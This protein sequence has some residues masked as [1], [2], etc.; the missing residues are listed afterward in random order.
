MILRPAFK[1]TKAT[2]KGTVHV[3]TRMLK[4]KRVRRV[5]V[6]VVKKTLMGDPLS[7]DP[8]D[9]AMILVE[10]MMGDAATNGIEMV[11]CDPV[12][13][14]KGKLKE[15][16]THYLIVEP[17]ESY[18]QRRRDSRG[19]DE[20]VKCRATLKDAHSNDVIDEQVVEV[21]SEPNDGGIRSWVEQE[22]NGR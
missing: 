22:P 18:K 5:A 15:T 16:V 8:N 2:L 6:S 3:A 4:T 1:I 14:A 11:L 20:I 7:F 9:A 21:I 17:I 12:D 13:L 10:S 19:E